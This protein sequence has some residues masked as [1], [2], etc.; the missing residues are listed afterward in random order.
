MD[1]LLASKWYHVITNKK[2]KTLNV[3]NKCFKT[4]S[5]GIQTVK[6]G[7]V[8]KPS[9]IETMLGEGWK[10][11]KAQWKPKD[12]HDKDTDDAIKAYEERMRL[13]SEREERLKPKF[14]KTEPFNYD[15]RWSKYIDR[16]EK[17]LV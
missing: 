5:E 13:K 10:E 1:R 3:T 15:K 8:L 6:T 12:L 17:G 11:Y 7:M 2:K 16:K 9:Q 14:K 4:R